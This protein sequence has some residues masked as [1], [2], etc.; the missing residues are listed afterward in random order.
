MNLREERESYEEQ[1]MSE[2]ATLSKRSLG[3]LN[4]SEEKCEIRT[5]F[6]RDR[7]RILYSKAFRRLKHKTQ[8]FI[9]PEGDHYRTRLTHTLEVSQIARTIARSLKLNED[10]T[11]AISHGHDI[12]HTPFGHAGERV[13]NRVCPLGFKHNQQSLRVVDVLESGKG[14]NLTMEV[15]DGI[16]NHTGDTLPFTPEGKVVRMADRIA[17]INHDIDD[18]ITGKV[19]TEDQIPKQCQQLFGKTIGERIDSM[20]KNIVHHSKHTSSII[21]SREFSDAMDVLRQFMFEHVYVD[22]IAKK[23]EKKAENMLEYLYGYLYKNEGVI[24]DEYISAAGD[25]AKDRII[26]DYI[27]GMT[28]R[29]AVKIFEKYF[30]PKFWMSIDV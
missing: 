16:L 4:N 22:S 7:D 20:V 18:A 30:V 3:R 11:E 12:G 28:D 27:A 8:V 13:L 29:F 23:E 19:I 5:D 1:F 21:M 24:E 9:S 17:Y 6:Q 14:L 25:V 15:R 26:C 2:Y 10:L